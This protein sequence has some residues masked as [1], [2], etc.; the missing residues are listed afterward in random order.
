MGEKK[1]GGVRAEKGLSEL[2]HPKQTRKKK[3]DLVHSSAEVSKID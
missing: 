3:K 1:K 2:H